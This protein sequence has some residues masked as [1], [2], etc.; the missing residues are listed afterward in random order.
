MRL[1][2]YQAET[3]RIAA[4]QSAVLDSARA[5]VVQGRPLTLLEQ[6]GVLHA[7]Q[8]LVENAIG[9]AKHIL[10]L[11][12]QPVPT[13]AH[14]AFATLARLGLVDTAQL[15][16]WNAVIGMRN[17]IVHEYMNIDMDRILE[18][19]TQRKEQFV[20]EFLQTPFDAVG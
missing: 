12:G 18:L 10:K 16:Q 13:S 15:S 19:V 9:K 7:L 2:L 6:G 17:R 11:R 20:V 14:D 4:E 5:I 3:R 8:I 1:E